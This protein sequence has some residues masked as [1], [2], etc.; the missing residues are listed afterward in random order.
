[1]VY[2]I[3]KRIVCPIIR[4]FLKKAEGIGNIP[5]KGPFIIASN[6]ESYL[7]AFLIAS[8]IVPLKNGKVHFLANK[9]PFWHFFGDKVAR[10]WAGCVPLD[11]E[12]EKALQ[13]L[14]FLLKKGE[15]VGIFIDGPLDISAKLRRG[16]TGVVRLALKSH[17]PILPIGIVGTDKI[18]PKGKII[19]NPKRAEIRIGKAMY[20]NGYYKQNITKELLRRLTDKI[21]NNILELKKP[22]DANK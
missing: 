2:P 10:D 12:K 6:H 4:L 8:V 7:D 9:G 22:Y 3:S 13:E 5:K 20:L 16:K 1:M 15:I 18:A 17:T 11:K 14:S 19:P 21:M